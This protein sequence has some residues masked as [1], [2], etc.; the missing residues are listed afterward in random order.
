MAMV[1]VG[2]LAHACHVSIF[3]L[4]IQIVAFFLFTVLL[5]IKVEG[6]RSENIL[7][8]KFEVRIIKEFLCSWVRAALVVGVSSAVDGRCASPVSS[9]QLLPPA[10]VY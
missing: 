9:S 4:I 6:G 8:S 2:V 7:T 1:D 10:Q 5:T 3:E